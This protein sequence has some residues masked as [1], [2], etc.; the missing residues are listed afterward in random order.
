MD[1]N[2]QLSELTGFSDEEKARVKGT[3]TRM[4]RAIIILSLILCTV[5][6]ALVL[7]LLIK[8]KPAGN[9]NCGS[10]DPFNVEPAEISTKV[11]YEP[12]FDVIEA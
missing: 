8:D 10:E 12:P 6:I 2:I 1:V 5:S 4:K 11:P 3:I 9:D 7:A